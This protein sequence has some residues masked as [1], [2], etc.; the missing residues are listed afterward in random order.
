MQRKELDTNRM[1]GKTR[2]GMVWYDR[3]GK[4]GTCIIFEVAIIA[5][6]K[7]SCG[8]VPKKRHGRNEKKIDTKIII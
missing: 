1:V 7:A 5:I 6:H 2:Y 4:M 8:H 3:V